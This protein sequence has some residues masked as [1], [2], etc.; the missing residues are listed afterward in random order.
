M[1]SWLAD[2]GIAYLGG[3][4]IGAPAGIATTRL[5]RG[6]ISVTVVIVV[7]MV[8]VLT[9]RRVYRARTT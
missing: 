2:L 5:T 9:I 3:V 7:A 1:A 4:L 6:E 8:A